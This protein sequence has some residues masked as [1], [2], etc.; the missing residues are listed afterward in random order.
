MRVAVLGRTRAL[1]D[2][3]R[4]IVADG[5][6]VPIVWTC[7]TESH[8]G[9]TED[10]FAELANS[11]GA[12]FINDIAIRRDENIER[13]RSYG[14]DV[15]ISVNWPTVLNQR[16]LEIFPAGVLNAHAGD[17]PRFRGNACPNWAILVGEPHVGLC[18]HKMAVELDAG[19][20][21]VRDTLSLTSGTYVGEVMDWVDKRVPVLFTD[22]LA[23]IAGGETEFEVQPADPALALRCYP[24]RPEDSRIDWRWPAE[25]VMRM[26]RASSHP[27]SGAF[28]FLEAGSKVTVWRAEISEVKGATLA[29]PGQVC[30]V[31]DT[32]PVIACGEGFVALVDVSLEDEE[33]AVQAK[34]KISKSLRNRLT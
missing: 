34:A 4:A 5:H 9:V 7:G 14:C 33:G 28:A 20:V 15:A 10:D 6:T 25:Q 17:L 31:R 27:Y 19:P 22:A 29:I 30:F 13:L 16:V 8:Y 12:D 1:L 23:R 24:R 32:N 2:A 26:V 18:I 21:I 11:L 3:T